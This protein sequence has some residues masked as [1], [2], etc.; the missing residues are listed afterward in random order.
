VN[1]NIKEIQER[2]SKFIDCN[3][4]K[5]IETYYGVRPCRKEGARIE[6]DKQNNFLIHNYGHGTTG[7]SSSWGSAIE[8]VR[9]INSLQ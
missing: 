5:L 6:I 2:C 3:K 1:K 7:Y 9:L 8:V 4:M